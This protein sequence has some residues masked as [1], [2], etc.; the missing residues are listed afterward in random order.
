MSDLDTIRWGDTQA[1]PI[2]ATG[3]GSVPLFRTK[4]L[5]A[6]RWRRPLAWVAHVSIDGSSLLSS[7]TA[8]IPILA[9]FTIGVGGAAIQM[10]KTYNFAPPYAAI[11]DSFQIAAQDIQA[12]IVQLSFTPIATTQEA[13]Q[14]G[15]VV[16]PVQE[17]FAMSAILDRMVDAPPGPR[18]MEGNPALP[19]DDGQLHYQDQRVLMDRWSAD[20]PSKRNRW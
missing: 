15:I 20:D 17:P 4:Q 2:P 12:D 14:V 1:I 9:R 18:W 10:V 19:F 16:A 5:V 8:T 6:A 11:F 13:L 3:L 7:E